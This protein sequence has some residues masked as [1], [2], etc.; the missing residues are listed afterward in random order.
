MFPPLAFANIGCLRSSKKLRVPKEATDPACLTFGRYV[1]S[2]ETD[3]QPHRDALSHP[4]YAAV[5]LRL[6]RDCED[7][8]SITA[9]AEIDVECTQQA[10]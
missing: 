10:R 6:N 3:G 2:L 8:W 5:V 7:D 4:P 1:P 9:T